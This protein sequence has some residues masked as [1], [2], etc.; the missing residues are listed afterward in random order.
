MIEPTRCVYSQRKEK[1]MLQMVCLAHSRWCCPGDKDRCHWPL[2]H[3]GRVSHSML[4][5]KLF[6]KWISWLL[7]KQAFATGPKAEGLN[8]RRQTG[9]ALGEGS[10]GSWESSFSR[11]GAEPGLAC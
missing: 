8:L 10:W 6:Y 4:P 5:F 3:L 7:T 1:Q 2:D 11:P 9:R